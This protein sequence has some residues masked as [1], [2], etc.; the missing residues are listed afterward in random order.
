VERKRE[1]DSANGD[2][3]AAKLDGFVRRK[4]VKQTVM[5]TVYGVTNYGATKQIAKQLKDIDEYEGSVDQGS[6]YLSKKTF[7]SLNELFTSSQVMQ[8]WLTECA[9]VI[10]GE[11]QRNVTW[12]TPLGLPVVQ[13]YSF[14]ACKKDKTI[15][16]DVKNMFKVQHTAIPV[17]KV[18]KMK[19]RNGFP[20]NFIHSL[21][22]SHMM[23]TAAH[24]WSKGITFASVHDCYWTHVCDVELMN[25]VCR[26]QFISL[27]SSPILEKL[28]EF[29]QQNYLPPPYG[30]FAIKQEENL[31]DRVLNVTEQRRKMLFQSIPKKGDLDLNVVKDSVYFF[32]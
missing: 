11:C 26:E 19:H 20:P 31:D 2:V 7:E 9:S 12:I 4:V 21:D 3:V 13:P 30:I 8:D 16:L 28:S 15:N 32:S 18:N 6:K 27:H 1:E 5:T 24:L 22:S 17:L 25:K 14:L 23:L 29:F 10:A